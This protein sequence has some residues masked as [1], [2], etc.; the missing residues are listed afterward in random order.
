MDMVL[1]KAVPLQRRKRSRETV[2]T[3]P[4]KRLIHAIF[5]MRGSV[6]IKHP[7]A[8]SGMC[9][10]FVEDPIPKDLVTAR[11][12]LMPNWHHTARHM[13]TCSWEHGDFYPNL[14]TNIKPPGHMLGAAQK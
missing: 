4:G 6:D 3:S 12:M 8:N 13:S 10:R 2:S 5:G 14:T 9:A 7:H 11:R 1:A